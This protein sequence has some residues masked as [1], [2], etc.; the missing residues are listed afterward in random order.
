M[1]RFPLMHRYA[2]LKPF[3]ITPDDVISTQQQ[4]CVSYIPPTLG[5]PCNIT[6]ARRPMI[7]NE[8]GFD[9]NGLDEDGNVFF[10][11]FFLNDEMF[12]FFCLNYNLICVIF[13]TF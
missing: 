11:F 10:F 9:R 12:Q 3:D 2:Q 6:M 1:P 5:A 4:S 13:G 7:R 8:D